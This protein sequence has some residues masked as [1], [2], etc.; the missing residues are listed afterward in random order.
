MEALQAPL[1]LQLVPGRWGQPHR[2]VGTIAGHELW[3]EGVP[4][5][6]HPF[7]ALCAH[8]IL[9][10]SPPSALPIAIVP[11]TERL[12]P[13]PGRIEVGD[14]AFDKAVTVVGPQSMILAFLTEKGRAAVWEV[15]VTLQGRVVDGVIRCPVGAM[16]ARVEGFERVM[17]SVA[18]LATALCVESDNIPNRLL[19]NVCGDLDPNVRLRNLNELLTAYPTT[20]EAR[21][22]VGVARED[23][24]QRVQ[25][26]GA[27]HQEHSDNLHDM[28]GIAASDACEEVRLE[29]LDHLV[30]S[31]TTTD[32]IPLLINLLDDPNP[33]IQCA[34]VRGLGHLKALACGDS[35]VELLDGADTL[36][37]RA[38]TEVLGKLGRA[39]VQP[40]LLQLLKHSDEATRMAAVEALGH[41]GTIAVIERLTP[42][43]KGVFT[44]GTLRNAACKAL[45]QIDARLEAQ[46]SPLSAPIRRTQTSTGDNMDSPKPPPA[47]A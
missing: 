30:R 40:I 24:D 18:E 41:V 16:S 27:K 46:S 22:A 8:I 14:V 4:I 31:G 21:T 25:L 35:L 1:G 29:A 34:A 23:A 44:N 37:V 13:T 47:A 19:T 11:A 26:A 36:V 5:R 3:V 7:S 43:T 38:I 17:T 15:V 2:L 28:L 6:A 10:L 32:V 20:P 42:Y 45:E 9:K 33:L 12:E 39:D